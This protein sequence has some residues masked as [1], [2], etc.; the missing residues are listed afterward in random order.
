MNWYWP[1]VSPLKI[2]R[3]T[4]RDILW[5]VAAN[6]WRMM[7][8]MVFLDYS[9][10]VI[11][12]FS[13]FAT[14]VIK[15]HIGLVAGTYK[16]QNVFRHSLRAGLYWNSHS[17]VRGVFVT[18]ILKIMT[19]WCP[20]YQMAVCVCHAELNGYFFTCTKFSQSSILLTLGVFKVTRLTWS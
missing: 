19:S 11:S 7:E 17:S 10:P 2:Y 15:I 18:I 20:T 16:L 14:I 3:E 6:S 5:N 13:L 9:R 8:V 1:K 12:S 4:T